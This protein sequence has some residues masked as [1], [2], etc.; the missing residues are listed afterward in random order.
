MIVI[1][2]FVYGILSRAN[3]TA[4]VPCVL[5]TCCLTEY[6]LLWACFKSGSLFVWLV[7]RVTSFTRYRFSYNPSFSACFFSRNSVFLSQQ[8]SRNSVSAC[9]FSKANGA[10]HWHHHFWLVLLSR[11]IHCCNIPLK[12]HWGIHNISFHY[13]IN[14]SAA[15]QYKTVAMDSLDVCVLYSVIVLVEITHL[16]D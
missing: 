16:Y 5:Y 15:S 11:L 2:N 4:M 12:N 13:L 3:Q 7:E 9:F 6:G 14:F 10:Y 8:I 1:N